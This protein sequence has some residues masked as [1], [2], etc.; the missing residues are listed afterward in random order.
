MNIIDPVNSRSNI[1]PTISFQATTVFTVDVC[2]SKDHSG[3][4]AFTVSTWPH[5]LALAQGETGPGP[6]ATIT[7]TNPDRVASWIGHQL[8]GSEAAAVGVIQ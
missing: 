1:P 3:K 4:L 6:D 8:A 2:P 7:T 5:P